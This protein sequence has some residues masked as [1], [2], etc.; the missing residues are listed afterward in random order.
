MTAFVQD[1]FD[2]RYGHSL[3]LNRLALAEPGEG[4]A[5]VSRKMGD[6]GISA[7]VKV[8]EG[9]DP[10]PAGDISCALGGNGVL[11]THLQEQPFYVGRDVAILRP[12]VALTKAQILFYCLCIKSNRFRYSY[13]RQANK[14]IR[15]LEVP[16]LDEL[17]E[18]IDSID[19]QMFEGA[20]SPASEQCAR[21]LSDVDW[22]IFSISQ[23]FEVRKGKRL[24]KAQLRKRPGTVPFIGAIDSN[25]GVAA[26]VDSAIHDG[27]TITVNYNGAGVA[28]A[29]YQPQPFWASDD[30]NVLYP[31]FDMVPEVGLF[32]A[33]VIGKEKYRFSYGRKWHL[34]RMKEAPIRLPCESDGEL[35]IAYME[36]YIQSL[37]FS[38]GL[39]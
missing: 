12:K 30:V 32:I 39:R 25:N 1:I 17:P 2:V 7:F 24:T 21:D 31:K 8:V 11:T 16:S 3:E 26:S 20:D 34:E 23:L 27:G 6:N 22:K 18:W 28:D 9:V 29:F 4:V 5:F 13:G 14:T 35:N 15:I 33:T 37:P 36:K 38:K 10:A 19:V